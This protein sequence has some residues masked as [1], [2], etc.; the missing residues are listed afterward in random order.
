VE[1]NSKFFISRSPAL[2]KYLAERQLGG[3]LKLK[4]NQIDILLW[5]ILN[6]GNKFW[7]RP[8]S[9]FG[10]RSDHPLD[11]FPDV[12]QDS[13]RRSGYNLKTNFKESIDRE[14]SNR[15]NLV[16]GEILTSIQLLDFKSNEYFHHLINFAM[17][18]FSTI[19][20]RDF[21]NNSDP[22]W[23]FWSRYSSPSCLELD[24]LMKLLR[25]KDVVVDIFMNSFLNF[26]QETLISSSK[27]DFSHILQFEERYLDLFRKNFFGDYVIDD[28]V[29][30]SNK[31][32][33]AVYTEINNLRLLSCKAEFLEKK[34]TEFAKAGVTHT[35]NSF[36]NQ[37]FE[38]VTWLSGLEI[39]RNNFENFE[40]GNL[41]YEDLNRS[42]SQGLVAL[43]RIDYHKIICEL[44]FFKN[45]VV[46]S[47][48]DGVLICERD[49]SLLPSVEK[50]RR[51]LIDRIIVQDGTIEVRRANRTTQGYVGSY[52]TTRIQ[53]D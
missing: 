50:V 8:S 40:I 30:T 29:N 45:F 17:T 39:F 11:N 49:Y 43:R 27:L 28:F 35:K 9:S 16:A 37:V 3:N 42:C 38:K 24:P 51:V 21:L 41:N 33:G 23:M 31:A 1:K 5:R 6:I 22:C 12:S 19:I 36:T 25:Q 48:N 26:I 32:M 13:I 34:L 4:G 53:L 7:D 44:P 18:I 20:S 47:G 10:M 2:E 15:L 14:I 46:Y 52:K